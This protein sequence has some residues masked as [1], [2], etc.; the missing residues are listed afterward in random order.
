MTTPNSLKQIALLYLLLII[1]SQLIAAP[2]NDQI[3]TAIN[4]EQLP[5]THQ[6]DTTGAS[7]EPNEILPQCLNEVSASVWYQY[8]ATEKTAVV[9]DTFGSDYDTVL[10]IWTG[11]THPLTQIACDDDSGN[12]SQSQINVELEADTTYYIN[13]SGYDGETGTLL[14]NALRVNPLLNDQLAEAI[15]IIPDENFLYSH[16]QSIQGASLEFKEALASCAQRGAFATVWYQ[17]TPPVTQRYVFNTIGSDYNTVLALWTG[18]KHPL[19]EVACNDDNAM[20]QSLLGIELKKDKTYYLSIA[21]GKSGSGTLE[22]LRGLLVLNMTM[23]PPND[24]LANAIVIDELPYTNR[25]F[26]GGAT[27][28][29]D[30]LRPTCA[31]A[32][33]SVWYLFTPTMDYDNISFITAGSGYDT[34]LSIW[35]GSQHPLTDVACNDNVIVTEQSNAS[36]IT[37]PLTENLTYYIDISGVS[38]ETGDLILRV[39]EGQI[40]FQIA[41]LSPSTTVQKCQSLPLAVNL[42]T[43]SGDLIDLDNPM[44]TQ[45]QNWVALPFEYQWH[46]GQKGG[47]SKE[48]GDNDYRFRTPPLTETTQYWLRIVN[49]TGTLDSE[50]ITITVEDVENPN[51]GGVDA[52]G[53]PLTTQTHFI[54]TVTRLSKPT[55]GVPEASNP[56]ENGVSIVKPNDLISVRFAIQTDPNHLE[57]NFDLLLVANYNSVDN[58]SY[59]FMRNEQGTWEL[60]DGDVARLIATETEFQLSPCLTIDVFEGMLTGMPGTFS[61]YAGYRNGDNG[62]IFF[63]PEPLIFQVKNNE[64]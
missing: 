44:K 23:P 53:A 8:Q 27:L 38:G 22:D 10:S 3:T 24:D 1:P 36:Q 6:Q 33:S 11:T 59:L 37:I 32:E 2:T 40:D 47:E 43:S 54:G 7:N 29:T 48:V 62:T 42:S 16:T 15:E 19:T 41:Q 13:V 26:T 58:L 55:E 50:P 5:Y 28:E 9:F 4:I 56:D 45:W 30:E 12:T 46:Q 52:T 20:S 39:E 25:Q 64:N 63:N 14:L 57:Q 35:Q 34:A 61:V 31:A 17:F 49:P 60:W 51:G 18:R 21:A